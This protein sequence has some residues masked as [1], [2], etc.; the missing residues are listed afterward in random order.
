MNADAIVAVSAGVVAVTQLIKWAGMKDSFGPIVVILLS[1]VG[2]ALWLYSQETWPPVR[3][4]TWAIA[5]GWVAVTLT[6]AGT[7][8]FTRAAVSSVTRA[9]PPPND[10]AG[11]SPTSAPPVDQDALAEAVVE[12]IRAQMEAPPAP[13]PERVRTVSGRAS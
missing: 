6:A 3:T 9:T 11:S 10:G 2:V 8:G 5:S 13:E 7:F 12:K 1:G 4:D